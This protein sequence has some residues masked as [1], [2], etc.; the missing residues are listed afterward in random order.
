MLHF[1]FVPWLSLQCI[2]WNR[3][4]HL[5]FHLAIVKLT[6]RLEVVFH[7]RP[8]QLEGLD[9]WGLYC[10]E[11]FEIDNLT[12]RRVV[13][14]RLR[15]AAAVF[16]L[17]AL[18]LERL[19]TEYYQRDIAASSVTEVVRYDQEGYYRQAAALLSITIR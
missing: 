7:Q 2:P 13:Q 9:N 17:A 8:F 3:N 12:R 19:D 10:I 15:H 5:N 4:T 11:F 14:I 18:A 1:F 6:S 16:T